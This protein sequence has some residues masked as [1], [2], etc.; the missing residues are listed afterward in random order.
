MNQH[1]NKTVDAAQK[2]SSA[3]KIFLCGDVM[4]GRGIDQVLPQPS[5][6]IL[7]ESF[8]KDARRYV[9]IAEQINGSIASP[10]HFA[11]VW[12]DA[13]EEFE[14]MS[15]DVK[16]INLET[17]I[18]TSNA[19]WKGKGINYRMHPGN[20]PVL[21]A[22]G[23][24]IC[25]LANNHVLDWGYDGLIDTL[26]ALQ[27]VNIKSIGA[28]R[29][30]S[31]AM[32]PA[33]KSVPGKGRVLVFAFGLASS[34][35][36]R[37][38]N[39]GR[40]APGVYLLRDLSHQSLLE[41]QQIV[42]NHKRRGDIVV[43]SIHWGSNWGFHIPRE[44]IS[45]AHQLIEAGGVDIVHGHSSHHVRAIE[46]YNTKLILYGCGDFINDYEGIGGHEHFRPYLS[47]M[48]FATLDP[49]TG[50]LLDLQMTPTQIKRFQVKR[51]SSNDARWLKNTLTSEGSAF[52]TR[53][54]MTG[55]D[56]LKLMWN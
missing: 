41:V 49:T 38:W 37:T 5:N 24:D 36:P 31:D 27:K 32:A 15:P 35:I 46:V 54:E 17:S 11:Y 22:A 20:V 34:G 18:T 12:G 44:Q 28:G 13:L 25:A 42:A 6:P 19:Y 16:I 21:T 9:R 29:T 43:A 53:I 7:F 47:L 14:R 10:V 4:T 30:L 40:Q 23:I 55:G 8:V 56:T 1:A 52:G 51:A 3:V 50:K 33:A 39:A 26:E 2:V 45:F 48:Y